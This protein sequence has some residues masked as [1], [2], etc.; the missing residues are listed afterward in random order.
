MSNPSTVWAQLSLPLLPAGSI[1]FVTIDQQTIVTD[2]GNFQYLPL[3]YGS[4]SGSQLPYQLTVTNGL[5]VSYTSISL[6]S[7]T[8]T[9][10]KPSGRI[11]VP[12]GQSTVTVTS[13]CCFA[14]SMILLSFQTGDNII[15][16][17]AVIPAD[18]S[19]VVA[20]GGAAGVDI[21]FDFLI[22]NRI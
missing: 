11:K 4:F 21:T 16:L 7:T 18:G 3:D 20:F 10:N 15:S 5:R 13:N 12:Q 17:Y 1:P 8:Y 19:F 6:A 22:V 14:T 9:I 2:V